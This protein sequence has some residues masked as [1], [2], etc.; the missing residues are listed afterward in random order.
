MM[1]ATDKF[2]ACLQACFSHRLRRQRKFF[3]AKLFDLAERERNDLLADLA[4]AL[5]PY[6]AHERTRILTAIGFR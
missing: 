5:H 6:P 4:Y 3:N 2:I 1:T